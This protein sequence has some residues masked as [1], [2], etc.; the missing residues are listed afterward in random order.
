M[1]QDVLFLTRVIELSSLTNAET[2]TTNDQDLLHVDQVP[3][4]S[5]GAAVQVGL[6]IR[7]FLSLV[8]CSRDLCESAQLAVCRS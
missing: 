3:S 2:S 1:R 5:N 6:R 7:C 4:A 8:E